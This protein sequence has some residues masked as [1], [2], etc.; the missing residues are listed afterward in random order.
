MPDFKIVRLSESHN[1]VLTR[2]GIPVGVA[3]VGQRR[4]DEKVL[5]PLF[6]FDEDGNI[7]LTNS[8]KVSEIN[9]SNLDAQKEYLDSM[10]PIKPF[11]YELRVD[12]FVGLA[13]TDKPMKVTTFTP[14]ENG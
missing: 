8:E 14:P 11:R 1:S 13:A 7:V 6:A 4:E 9:E 2:D 10:K 12:K 5:I 3:M